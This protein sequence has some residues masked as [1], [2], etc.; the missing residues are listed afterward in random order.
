MGTL[1]ATNAIKS[2]YVVVEPARPVNEESLDIDDFIQQL[3]AETDIA[4]GMAE[5]RKWIGESI[6][7]DDKTQDLRKLRLNAGLSQSQLAQL[8]GLKQPNISAIE[9]GNRSPSAHT[10]INLC[11]ALSVSADVLLKALIISEEAHV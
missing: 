7:D 4:A 2:H 1:P 8:V 3:S 11:S 5:A 10:I 6:S 9:S